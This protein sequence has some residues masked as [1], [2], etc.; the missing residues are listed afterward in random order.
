MTGQRQLHGQPGRTR[1]DNET[2]SVA[3]NLFLRRG[4]L[5]ASVKELTAA[6]GI[7]RP[8]L[9]RCYGN[10][11]GLF[12]RALELH[13]ERHI[14]YL[15]SAICAPTAREVVE[16]LLVRAL[17]DRNPCSGVQGFIGLFS[18]LPDEAEIAGLREI[19]A[20]HHGHAIELLAER[21]GQAR[22]Q[23]EF[24]AH[25]C[26]KVVAYMLE[27]VIHGVAVQGRNSAPN[28]DLGEL[29]EVIFSGLKRQDG[30]LAELA[31]TANLTG[32]IDALAPGTGG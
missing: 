16:H 29:I 15:R 6:M 20:E 18:A 27:F 9:Y 12:K 4:Y 26:P 3:L 28:V 8:S 19:V 1:I 24:A 21:F 30:G 11:E 10:K 2:L 5:G 7:A 23:G 14:A 22:D 13:S 31:Q 25:A 32:L 17:S